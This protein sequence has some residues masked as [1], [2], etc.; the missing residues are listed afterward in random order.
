MSEPH[1]YEVT[2]VKYARHE[3][4]AAGS[5]LHSDDIHDSDATLDFFVWAAVSKDRTFVI[6]T[7]FN[8]ETAERRGRTILRN[9]AEGLGLIGIDAKDVEDVIITHLHYDHVGN[10]D[11]F[12]K[13]TFH[14]QDREMHYATGRNM[15]HQVFQMPYDIDHVTG[16]VREVY[17]GRVNFIDGDAE[18][19]P[20]LSV[21]HIGG[22]T[23]GMMSVR[24]FTKRGWVVLASDALHLY[25]NMETTNPF[26]LVYSVG[27]MVQGYKKLQALADSPDHIIAGH[28][29]RVT[30]QYPAVSDELDGIAMRLDVPPNKD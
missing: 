10:F 7:G 27:D 22:H 16:M 9:P 6:D 21:H 28:D 4:A 8:A 24:V 19:A 20:G 30:R 15:A 12:P 26:P 1:V 3:R 11:R 2:A 17:A 29:P 14:L 13:A 5:F 23:D 18:L 25:A